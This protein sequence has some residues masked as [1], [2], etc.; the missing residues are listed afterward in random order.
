[1]TEFAELK[2]GDYMVF[3]SKFY[4]TVTAENVTLIGI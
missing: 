2:G 3:H 4:T 1:M